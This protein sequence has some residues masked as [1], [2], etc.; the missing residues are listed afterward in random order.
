MERVVEL[1]GEPR[2]GQQ[3]LPPRR[4]RDRRG[5]ERLDRIDVIRAGQNAAALKLP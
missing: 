2:G 4:E 5:A 3:L 1:G